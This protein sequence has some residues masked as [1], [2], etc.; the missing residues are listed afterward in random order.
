MLCVPG[1]KDQRKHARKLPKDTTY[2]N[3]TIRLQ[4]RMSP[5]QHTRR[6]SVH[7]D[8]ILVVGGQR[9]TGVR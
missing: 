8:D 3:R 1:V 4:Q 2:P 5:A 6:R 9:P 7:L